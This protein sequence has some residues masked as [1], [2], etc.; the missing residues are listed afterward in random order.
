M[1]KAKKDIDVE[2]AEK[3][4]ALNV[5][6]EEHGKQLDSISASIAGVNKNFKT[7]HT[8]QIKMNGRLEN[9]EGDFYGWP[10]SK[11]PGLK[12]RFTTLQ[13]GM[14]RAAGYVAGVASLASIVWIFYQHFF[15]GK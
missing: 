11:E 1:A 5:Y 2:Q 15:A 10:K 13:G 8:D 3:I 7:M 9:L 14:D 6:K 12:S 4:A